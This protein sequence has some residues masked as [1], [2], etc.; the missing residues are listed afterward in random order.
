MTYKEWTAVIQVVGSLL[1]SWWV[2]ADLLGAGGLA[3]MAEVAV[4]LLWGIGAGIVFNI[5][6]LILVSI[7]VGI[8]GGKPLKDERADERDRLVEMR[9]ARNAYV[10][11]SLAAALFLGAVAF[12]A[13]PMLAAVGLFAAPMLAGATDA[14]SRLA[15]YRFG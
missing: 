10:V 14:L 12:G 7:L 15:Y 4:R 2:A 9:S 1:I 6:A 8:V 5:A 13:E 11:G 3:T